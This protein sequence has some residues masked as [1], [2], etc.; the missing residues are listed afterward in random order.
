MIEGCA[1]HFEAA[2]QSRTFL[3]SADFVGPALEVR[4]PSQLPP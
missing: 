2:V 1:Y 4:L 3:V